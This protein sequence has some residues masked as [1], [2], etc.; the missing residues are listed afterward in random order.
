MNL[1]HFA[2]IPPYALDG[3][4]AAYIF[5][6]NLLT[7]PWSRCTRELLLFMYTNPIGVGEGKSARKC[8]GNSKPLS[9]PTCSVSAFIQQCYDAGRGFASYPVFAI[10]L[11]ES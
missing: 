8:M 3:A 7:I 2:S 1:A 9:R 4:T 11:L 6:C 5:D 10:Y